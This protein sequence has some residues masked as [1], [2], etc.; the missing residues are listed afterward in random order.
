[1]VGVRAAQDAAEDH[2]REPDVGAVLRLARHL[3]DA[4]R[5]DRPGADDLV[6]SALDGGHAFCSSIWSAALRTARTILS[7]PVQR[8]RLFAS[9]KRTRCS[10]G[11]GSL[12]NR[13]LD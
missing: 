4:V 6:V 10:S 11:C 7:Y 3:L 12:S 1:R 5:T 2:A 9:Q 8:H 13:A